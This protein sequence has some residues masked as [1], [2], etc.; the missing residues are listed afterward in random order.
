MVQTII[1]SY[2]GK[3]NISSITPLA[4]AGSNRKYFRIILKNKESYI[5]C[6]NDHI[7]ENETFFYFTEVFSKNGIQVPSIPFINEGRNIYIQTDLGNYSLLDTVMNNNNLNTIETLYKKSL[8]GLISMQTEGGKQIDFSK[9][10]AAAKFDKGAVL[11]DLN[12]FKYY[13]LD[14]QDIIYNKQDLQTEFELL[15]ISIEKISPVQFMFRDFQGR[16]IM[17]KDETP[18]FIDYQGGMQGP[19]QYDVASLLWQAKAALSFTLKEELYRFYKNELSKRLQFEVEEFD[20][21]YY[22]ILLVRLMQVLGAYG[23]RGIIEQRSHFLSSIPFGL[24][25]I[26]EWITNYA[27]S[28]ENYP[29]L[30]EALCQLIAPKMKTKYAMEQKKVDHKLKVLLQSF[31]YKKGIPADETGNGG[32]FMFDCRGIL[33]PG[34]FEEYKKLTGRDQPVIDFLESKTAIKDFLNHAKKLVDISVKDYLDRGFEHLQISFGCTGG[35]HRSVYCTDSMA[36]YLREKYGIQVEV[37][38]LI[39]DEK[40]WIN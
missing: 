25:N 10:Y 4:Q 30:K 17:I 1:E 27:S 6:Q 39:Q 32:G 38:H 40:N 33:N 37:K 35:Q 15:A 2:F 21:N 34:R 13:F 18:Y 9:C 28:I 14:L 5:A 3:E 22:K 11:A 24:K 12:Y 19:L 23:L 26:E 20:K 36:Q 16:N 31:S 29:T 8:R 7:A